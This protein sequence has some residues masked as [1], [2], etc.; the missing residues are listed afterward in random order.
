MKRSDTNGGVTNLLSSIGHTYYNKGKY[1]DAIIACQKSLALGEEIGVIDLQKDACSCLY[2]V[3][4]VLGKGIKALQ[5][6]EQMSVLEDSLN[7]NETIK[8]LQQ[9]EFNK[10]VLLDSI[11]TERKKLL[12]QIAHGNEIRELETNNAKIKAQRNSLIGGSLLFAILGFIG[13][14]YFKIQK[15]RNDKKAFAEALIFAQENERKRIARDLHD[16]VGQSL[17]LI[18]KQLETTHENTFENNKL[19]NTTLEEV[20]SI[21]RNLH[22]FQL[23]KFG[24]TT[25]ILD[26][27]DNIEKSTGL[28]I[29]KEIDDIDGMFSQ[30]NEIHYFRVVQE[31]LNNII[32]HANANAAKIT[33]KKS[34]ND[35]VTKVMDNGKGF[36]HE[37]IVATS[38]S[39]GLRTMNERISTLGG[40][41]KI[42]PNDTSG[43]IVVFII[44][45][46]N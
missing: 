42:E 13:Y 46:T 41:F 26:V 17:L 20:R 28:F 31:A 29:T 14:N 22:P 5:Y 15:D 45:K 4:K 7:V 10:Q 3:N 24:L 18:K 9:M 32:K 6:H 30:K 2:K 38:K 8:K 44:P 43:T 1:T 40:R 36:D 11:A 21:S 23:E 27:I 39:L 34:G 33:I 25:A 12:V 19:I 37:L 16:G 35:I